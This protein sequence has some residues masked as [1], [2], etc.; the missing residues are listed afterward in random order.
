MWI[1]GGDSRLAGRDSKKK[2]QL[3]T[4]ISV[5]Q[6]GCFLPN[7]S[8]FIYHKTLENRHILPESHNSVSCKPTQSFDCV[9]GN[10]KMVPD[11]NCLYKDITASKHFNRGFASSRILF[12][13]IQVQLTIHFPEHPKKKSFTLIGHSV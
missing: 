10:S 5:T 4:P 6:L 2:R 8:K 1:A 12:L 9:S 3:I 11:R 7:N 13:D